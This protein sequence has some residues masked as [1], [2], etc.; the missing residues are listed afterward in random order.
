MNYRVLLSLFFI[1]L[2]IVSYGMD[3]NLELQLPYYK[4]KIE[5]GDEFT[6]R[7]MISLSEDEINSN[8]AEPKSPNK[9]KG[10]K[11]IYFGDKYTNKQTKYLF[12]KMSST[13]QIVYNLRLKAEKKGVYKFGPIEYGGLKSNKLSYEIF[14]S[15]TS[16]NK[17]DIIDLGSGNRDMFILA[18]VSNEELYEGMSFE[19]IAKLYFRING[20]NSYEIINNVEFENCEVNESESLPNN[21]STEII[22]GEE[23]YTLLLNK[24]YVEPQK[25]GK[26]KCEN[27]KYRF[28]IATEE[29]KENSMWGIIRSVVPKYY[30]IEVPKLIVNVKRF[31]SNPP[32]GY[33]GAIGQFNIIS[34]V[35]AKDVNVGQ[36]FSLTYSINGTGNIDELV[37][38]QL[39]I[40]SIESE[41]SAPYVT[42]REQTFDGT[43]VGI[44]RFEYTI[45]PK[46][47]GSL[48]IL[49]IEFIFFNPETGEFE[50][51]VA[52][53]YTIRVHDGDYRENE[54]IES[55]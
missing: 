19:Y 11:I 12:G 48:E 26:I 17:E 36:V 45:T 28:M 53:G 8:F 20:L 5:V 31:P 13:Y 55:L 22:D 47:I 3:F 1:V 7:Y 30:D 49:P 6:I 37:M 41:I 2:S 25:S 21:L 10:C 27:G 40:N 43:E 23:Y 9:V 52:K 46:E 35:S 18:N 54:M 51:A 29:Y 4:D 50:T 44:T 14:E 32:Q 24:F 42:H 33:L 38:P 16:D 34:K 39:F 15:E